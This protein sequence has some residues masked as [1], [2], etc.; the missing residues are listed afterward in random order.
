MTR[1]IKVRARRG[2]PQTSWQAANSVKNLRHSQI[3]ILSIIERYGPVTDEEI[4]RRLLL[5][6]SESGARTRRK[7]LVDLGKVQ[8]SGLR[9]TTISGRKTIKWEVV[10]DDA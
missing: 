9:G 4:Y 2:D 10:P 5:Q 7:E 3:A 8:D 1:R 6:M